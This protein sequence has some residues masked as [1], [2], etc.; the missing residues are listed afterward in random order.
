MK[1]LLINNFHYR[2]GGSESV[3]FNTG[4]LLEEAGHEVVYFSFADEKNID[5]PYSEYFPERAGGLSGAVS[6]F[7]NRKAAKGL[8]KMLSQMETP[9]DIAHVHLIWGGLSPSI[10]KVLKRRSIPVVHTAHDYR[11]VCPGY[12]FLDSKGEICER[13]TGKSYVNCI[14]RRCAKG[15]LPKSILMALEARFRREFF[16]PAKLLGGCIFVS[17]FSLERHFAHDM[18]LTDCPAMTLY[19]SASD[20]FP[21]GWKPAVTAVAGGHSLDKGVSPDA[22][23]SVPG[24]GSAA[25]DAPA[26]PA[27]PAVPSGEEYLLYAGRLSREK[28]VETLIRAMKR[29]PR[30]KLKIAGTGPLEDDMRRMVADSG[31]QNVEFCGHLSPEE[32]RR[33]LLGCSYVIV[34]SQWYENNPMTII[35]ACA[36]AKPVIASNIGGIPEIVR[37]EVSGYLF[38]PGDHVGLAILIESA[39]RP[40]SEEYAGLCAKARLMYEENFSEPAHLRRLV[41]FYSKIIG[42]QKRWEASLSGASADAVAGDMAPGAAAVSSSASVSG[43]ASASTA[44][45]VSSSA[46]APDCTAGK[47]AALLFDLSAT[48]PNDSGK[49]HG[50]GKYG[51]VIFRRMVARGIPF[52]CFYDSSRWLNPEIA[53]IC[54]SNAI[55]LYDIAKTGLQEIVSANGFDTLYSCL[56]ERCHSI[57]GCRKIGTLH[58]LRDLEI[59]LDNWFFR[60]R[61]DFR[62]TARFI[63]KKCL[64]PYYRRRKYLHFRDAYLRS[65]MD[66][67]TVSNYT[68]DAIRCHF[69]ESANLSIP[70]FYSPCT[71]PAQAAQPEHGGPRK[72]LMVSA[73]RWEKNCLRAA[74]AIDEAI[75]AGEL[76]DVEVRLLGAEE[77][78]FR[79]KFKNPGAFRFFG[80]VDEDTLQREYA[81]AWLFVYPSI[82]EGFGYPPLEAMR[83]GVPVI[84]SDATSIPEVL[85]DAAIY[86]SPFSTAQIREALKKMGDEA[87]RAEFSARAEL[88]YREIKGRQE[89]DLDALI[90][91]IVGTNPSFY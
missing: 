56:P 52:S 30:V 79:H 12:L 7:Y 31:L 44:A 43:S 33:T 47:P 71:S 90:D 39:P 9:P 37:D 11:L 32:L 85:G 1:V 17:F 13:C 66:T 58:D 84:A 36:A 57:T 83:Y 40:G 6:Y 28:G 34:P 73:N 46:S 65:G 60:Y 63:L 14:F 54:A 81:S 24:A 35:E 10:L 51:E 72:I 91:Y 25:S 70:V 55:P 75:S 88:R 26:V 27:A 68:A 2:K 19:N 45:A 8:D 67:V 82:S 78:A 4:R 20:P 23:D 48:Q 29:I 89:V 22:V 18:A 74:I 59:P 38:D 61:A 86:F 87:T 62:A 77:G 76:K 49:R 16:P 64:A 15:S 69:P 5:S 80:Y 42:Q 53:E 21:E 41:A 50:G 3:Y